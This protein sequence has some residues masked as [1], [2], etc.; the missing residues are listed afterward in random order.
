LTGIVGRIIVRR[1]GDES[2]LAWNKVVVEMV[3]VSGT[4]VENAARA[5]EVVNKLAIPQHC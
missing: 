3:R 2:L 5:F 4:F 1:K